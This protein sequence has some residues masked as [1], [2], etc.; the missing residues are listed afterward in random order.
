[1]LRYKGTL[2]ALAMLVASAALQGCV[3]T[4][5]TGNTGGPSW[6]RSS[7][8]GCLALK[9]QQLKT[10]TIAAQHAKCG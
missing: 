3:G 8:N 2:A 5:M 6:Y 7:S 1:M 9:A 10:G 4:A